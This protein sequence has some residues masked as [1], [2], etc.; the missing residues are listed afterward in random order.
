MVLRNEKKNIRPSPASPGWSR[1]YLSRPPP[2]VS[3]ASRGN[4]YSQRGVET[5][6]RLPV[7]S[8]PV[9]APGERQPGGGTSMAR[10]SSPMMMAASDSIGVS[11]AIRTCGRSRGGGLQRGFRC[12]ERSPNQGIVVTLGTGPSWGGG[13]KT[14]KT[15]AKRGEMQ[16]AKNP[17]AFDALLV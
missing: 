11:V 4:S 14:G 13:S 10:C 2:G 12:D 15:G 17:T 16:T 6:V 8:C 9:E 1:L 3:T 5:I 7:E